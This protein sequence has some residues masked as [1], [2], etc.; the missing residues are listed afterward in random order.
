ISNALKFIFTRVPRPNTIA[1]IEEIGVAARKSQNELRDLTLI[2]EDIAHVFPTLTDFQKQEIAFALGGT[3]HVNLVISLLE[4]WDLVRKATDESI[5]SFGSA[6]R[7]NEKFMESYERK[8]AQLGASFQS[9]AV[10][11]G[12]SGLLNILKAIVSG[13]DA[14]VSLF[15]KLPEPVRVA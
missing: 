2:L 14:V 1:H 6:M 8:V 7:E 13:L 3:R 4:N 12:N 15:N 11:I 5:N 10:S 9:L